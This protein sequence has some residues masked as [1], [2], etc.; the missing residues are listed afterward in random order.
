ME[1]PKKEKE[2]VI[3][4]NCEQMEFVLIWKN[5]STVSDICNKRTN[6]MPST[7]NFALKGWFSIWN[8]S[9]LLESPIYNI[10]DTFL[11]LIFF[12]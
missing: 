4:K 8:Y 1:D 6:V 3:T 2:G 9:F 12:S 11:V 10:D 7:S 5:L